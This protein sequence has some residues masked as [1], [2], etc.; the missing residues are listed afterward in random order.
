[1]GD[2]ATLRP[3][4]DVGTAPGLTV[5]GR[6]KA[7]ADPDTPTNEPGSGPEAQPQQAE[8]EP[9]RRLI[10]AGFRLDANGA[11]CRG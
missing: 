11:W 4:A 9:E 2:E 6:P 3:L 10:A 1:M 5:K 7:P 8:P